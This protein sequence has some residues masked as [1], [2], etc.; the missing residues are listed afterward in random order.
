MSI[1]IYK[2]DPIYQ[3]DPTNYLNNYDTGKWTVLAVIKMQQ[4]T[5]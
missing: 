1:F 5:T 2:K 4:Q 3:S